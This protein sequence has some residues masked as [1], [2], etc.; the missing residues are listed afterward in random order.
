MLIIQ[1]LF[2]KKKSFF[3]SACQTQRDI[4]GE[5]HTAEELSHIRATKRERFVN[6]GKIVSNRSR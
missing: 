2:E 4:Y 1:F 6:I 5:Q 3:V